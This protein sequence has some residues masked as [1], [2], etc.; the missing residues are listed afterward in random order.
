MAEFSYRRCKSAIVARPACLA[1]LFAL[2]VVIVIIGLGYTLR[3]Y[4][5]EAALGSRQVAGNMLDSAD[6]TVTTIG[7]NA[8]HDFGYVLTGSRLRRDF[9]IENDTTHPY[10]LE[11]VKTTCGCTVAEPPQKTVP[12]GRRMVIPVH[13]TPGTRPGRKTH[14]VRLRFSPLL[15]DQMLTVSAFVRSP[16]AVHPKDCHVVVLPGET[17]KLSVV[18]ENYSNSDWTGVELVKR[19]NIDK[20]HWLTTALTPAD[21]LSTADKTA[22]RQRWIAL[23]Q[24]DATALVPSHYRSVVDVIGRTDAQREFRGELLIDVDVRPLA[25]VVPGNLFVL[26]KEGASTASKQVVFQ[27]ADASRS[28]S[29][30]DIRLSH[31]LPFDVEMQCPQPHNGIARALLTF[32]PLSSVV[33]TVRGNLVIEFGQPVYEEIDVPVVVVSAQRSAGR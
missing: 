18:I 11:S 22:P 17:R 13:F 20:Q 24:I 2:V 33:G 25:R 21:S 30:A 19:E 16:V 10:R 15:K 9:V 5:S 28:P 14:S 12:P 1:A 31:N 4:L 29:R 26:V 27:F 7:Q 23:L 6:A 3:R 8:Y 32:G